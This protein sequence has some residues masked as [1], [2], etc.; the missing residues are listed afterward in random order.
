MGAALIKDEQRA[1]AVLDLLDAIT[2]SVAAEPGRRS[3]PFKALRKALGY[4]VAA[5]LA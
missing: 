2:A 3:E 1:V 4:G 5:R